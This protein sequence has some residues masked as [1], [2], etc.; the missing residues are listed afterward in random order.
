MIWPLGVTAQ[1]AWVS[2]AVHAAPSLPA[3]HVKT[4]MAA[5]PALFDL[6][7][8]PAPGTGHVA[9]A[10]HGA[11]K[12]LEVKRGLLGALSAAPRCRMHARQA[13]R[14]VP[15]PEKLPPVLAEELA[16]DP[17]GF[18]KRHMSDCVWVFYSK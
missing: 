7:R 11:L 14:A 9:F 12:F 13:A 2:P 6:D 10:V 15:V 16:A 3:D 5:R 17:A 4:Y 18:V 8:A 1:L